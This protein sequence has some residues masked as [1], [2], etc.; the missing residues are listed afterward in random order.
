MAERAVEVEFPHLAKRI[1]GL[2]RV[3]KEHNTN[4][5]PRL[6]HPNWSEKRGLKALIFAPHAQFFIPG[7]IKLCVKICKRDQA[8]PRPSFRRFLD[9]VRNLIEQTRA[10]V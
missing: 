2:Y 10:S 7:H 4:V 5:L 8:G 3:R 1:S 9:G 6:H